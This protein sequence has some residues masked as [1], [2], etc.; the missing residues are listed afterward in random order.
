MT[1]TEILLF[2]LIIVLLMMLIIG[3]FVIFLELRGYST[4]FMNYIIRPDRWR[5]YYTR[6]PS[7]PY[8]DRILII[9]QS[10]ERQYNIELS[11]A[12]REMLVVPIKERLQYGPVDWEDVAKS[13]DK[14]VAST[15]EDGI[16]DSGGRYRN[17]VA[18]IK[19]FY[20]RFCNIPPFC[21]PTADDRSR[22]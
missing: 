18:V 20:R 13:I 7:T 21:D 2:I 8:D 4:E 5:Q 10:A 15:V 6:Q 11:W 9:I 19:A 14:I 16:R 1:I 22:G 12:A 3:L 17:A